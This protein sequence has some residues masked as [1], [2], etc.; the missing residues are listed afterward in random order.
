MAE[1]QQ[2]TELFAALTTGASADERTAT[3]SKV[4]EAVKTAGAASLASANVVEQLRAAIDNMSSAEAREGGLQAFAS[5]MQTVGTTAEPFLLS[6]IPSTLER[7]ADKVAPVRA[8]AEAAL[9]A[10]I[11][12][13]N[14]YSVEQVLPM[15]FDAMALQRNWMT[16][17]GAINALGS[18]VK[19]APRQVARC[20]PDI[21][22]RLTECFAD[23][24]QQVKDAAQVVTTECFMK[25]GN[26]DIEP[27][28][29]ALVSC[30]AR[31]A[32]TT[33]CIHKLAATTF[34]QQV[35]APPLAIIV[36][37]LVRGLR[38]RTTAIKRKSCVIIDNMAKLVELPED[39]AP[40][41]PKLLPELEKTKEE[42][43]D[44][45]CRQVA[46]K[47]YA[48][49]VRVSGEGKVSPPS[50]ITTDY[51]KALLAEAVPKAASS[52]DEATFNHVLRIVMSVAKHRHFAFEDW[53]AALG[54]FLT[55]I[56]G[57][58]GLLPACQKMALKA[59]DDSVRAAHAA[60]EVAEAVEDL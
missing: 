35:E 34:V 30:I 12:A 10:Y 31:P 19:T 47:A 52:L 55:P 36:P 58:D 15:L 13:L 22:P 14:P 20:L 57:A 32:E 45:E 17:L 51:A 11:A 40:F 21:V 27:F 28:V 48:T 23:A 46:A 24:K 2:V 9:N 44:P 18:M 16:K 53:T 3:A 42:V 7:L 50:H 8:A 39:A 5:I 33:D 37:L 26:R 4:A 6:L 29:P 56:T 54:A 49:L 59:E 60:D 43:A 1:I 25:N 41:L 38:E